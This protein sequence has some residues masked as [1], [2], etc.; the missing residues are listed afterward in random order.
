MLSTRFPRRVPMLRQPRHWD[1]SGV[2]P[3]WWTPFHLSWRCCQCR[4]VTSPKRRNFGDKWAIWF[5]PVEHR[6]IGRVSSSPPPRRS[7]TGYARPSTTSL[8]CPVGANRSLE[9]CLATSLPRGHPALV[10]TATERARGTS[11]PD[12]LSP[13]PKRPRGPGIVW[14]RCPCHQKFRVWRSNRMWPRHISC[15]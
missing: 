4:R 1:A 9:L 5:D 11:E 3:V 15:V 14:R 13:N 8:A 10:S 6:R 7:G 12:D 2:D